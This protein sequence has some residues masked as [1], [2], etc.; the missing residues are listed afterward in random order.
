MN[1]LF[2]KNNGIKIRKSNMNKHRNTII[3]DCICQKNKKLFVI[4]NPRNACKMGFSDHLWL[5]FL[6]QPQSYVVAFAMIYFDIKFF[7]T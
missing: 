4:V 6:D 2:S 3:L 7:V 1:T 5:P